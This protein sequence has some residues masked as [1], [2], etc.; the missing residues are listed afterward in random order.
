MQ[1]AQRLSLIKDL[2]DILQLTQ[3]HSIIKAAIEMLH[4]VCNYF[5]DIICV[6]IFSFVSASL[7]G[8][9]TTVNPSAIG[10]RCN[11]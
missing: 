11:R 6:P 2:E 9:S 3:M 8:H 5:A 1:R 4:R 7:R 10:N